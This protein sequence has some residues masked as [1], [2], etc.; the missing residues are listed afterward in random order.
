MTQSLEF[1]AATV[2]EAV[3]RACEKLGLSPEQVS[4]EVVD[5]GSAGFLGI[6]ARD[7]RISVTPASAEEGNAGP[8]ANEIRTSNHHAEHGNLEA[9]PEDDAEQTAEPEAPQDFLDEIE[10][11]VT[12]TVQKM[13]IDARVDVYDAG[14]YIAVDVAV[15]ETGLFIG[16]KGET[17][18]ALQYLLNVTM[19]KNREYLKRIVIDTEGYRQ[20]RIEAIQGMAHRTARRVAREQRPIELPPMTPSERRIVHIFLKD[21]GQV[22]TASQGSGDDRRVTISPA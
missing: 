12:R 6:G 9:H 22:T 19:Y 10:Q 7:A 16:Q 21:N 20:R 11:H 2:D 4:Y 14:E 8:D 5:P 3:Q 1:N 18:D 17:I 13:G 15:E